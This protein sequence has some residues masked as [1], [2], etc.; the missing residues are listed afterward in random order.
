MGHGSDLL[1]DREHA[2]E[3]A[4]NRDRVEAMDAEDLGLV[5]WPLMSWIGKMRFAWQLKSVRA[6]PD[7]LT[8]MEANLRL[9]GQKPWRP[10][11]SVG[12]PLGEQIF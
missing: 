4:K 6:S 1:G 11:S 10:R 5:T 9:R 3:Q 8:G 2:D 12:F 7:A